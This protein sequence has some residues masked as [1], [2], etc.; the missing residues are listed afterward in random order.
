MTICG[1]SEPASQ[2]EHLISHYLDM[3]G[4]ADAPASHHG[5]QIAVTTVTMACLQERVLAG[6]PPRLGPT[7]VDEAELVRAFGPDLGRACWAEVAAKRLDR[8]AADR[9]NA[10]LAGSWET[11]RSRLAAVSRPSAALR[12]V[13]RRAGA[14]ATPEELGW[15]AS[16]YREAVSRARLI[17]RRFTFLDLA[18]DSGILQRFL[19]AS[20]PAPP[21]S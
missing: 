16:V 10:R 3:R 8:G 13:L 20:R 15:S 7:P 14:P 4:P 9:L 5:E 21:A 19:V 12:D 1:G 18:G 2:G 17:R 11:W 6:G